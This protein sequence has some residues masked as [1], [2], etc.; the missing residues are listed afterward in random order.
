MSNI[1]QLN[2]IT[3]LTV[4]SVDID[5]AA[6]AL[7][8]S[9]ESCEFGSIKMLSPTRPIGLHKTIEHIPIPLINFIGYSKFMIEDLHKFVET[10]FCLCIQSDGFVLN[11]QLW[12]NEFLKYDYV[13]APWPN[14]VNLNNG[15][16]DKL[17][18]DKNKV[19]NGGFSLRSK[20]LLE[21]CS[22]IK[23]DELNFPIKSEDMI[24]CH[25]LYEE[26]LKAG[27]KFAPL[28]LASKFSIE[29]LIENQNSSLVSSFGFHGKHWLSN[30]YLQK[31]AAK[32][33]HP[34]EFSSLLRN[35]RPTQQLNR[36]GRLGRL[37]PCPCGSAKRFKDCHGKLI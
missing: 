17:Y 27:I 6:N 37:E 10:K 4:T 19:G 2:D 23:F 26:M 14:A 22:R 31:L 5:S 1:L 29:S 32:S 36:L 15:P 11:P 34:E 12:T 24:I 35:H 18:F 25:F 21:I 16:V 7:L 13:G 30:D 8:V 33:N 20:K 28:N 3:L 9:S